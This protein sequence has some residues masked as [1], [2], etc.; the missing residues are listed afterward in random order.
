[1]YEANKSNVV[2]Y[3]VSGVNLSVSAK[4]FFTT[5]ER[6]YNGRNT[7]KTRQRGKVPCLAF[8]LFYWAK[9]NDSDSFAIKNPFLVQ[10]L[11]WK[12]KCLKSSCRILSSLHSCIYIICCVKGILEQSHLYS[13]NKVKLMSWFYVA[14]PVAEPEEG[15]CARAKPNR[16]LNKR[17]D[18]QHYCSCRG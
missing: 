18:V 12:L 16:S 3:R 2:E 1:M 7:C 4:P 5:G 10:L 17:I 8:S 14:L 6:M 9:F 15:L 11:K 13:V